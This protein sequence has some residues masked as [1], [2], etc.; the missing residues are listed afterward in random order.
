MPCRRRAASQRHHATLSIVQMFIGLLLFAQAIVVG[1]DVPDISADILAR[2]SDLLEMHDVV[3]GP[4]EDGGYYLVGMRTPQ[5][6]LFEGIPW[7]T[8]VVLAQSLEHAA[9][10]DLSVA[11]LSALPTL[12]DLD[13]VDVR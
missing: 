9:R 11:P 3:Y 12:L 1:T 4:V 6:A 2:A 13:T 8:S 7:S 5:P 10:A